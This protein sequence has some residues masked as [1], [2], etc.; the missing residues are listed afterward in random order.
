MKLIVGLGNP[1]K[2]YENTRHNVGFMAVDNYVLNEEVSKT[3]KFNGEM[4]TLNINNEKIM[5]LKPLKYM[6]LSG[7]VIKEYINYY[8]IDIEDILIIVDD[9]N[10]PLGTI[11]L[12]YKGSSGG[13]NGLED[14]ANNLQ[15]EEYK[16]LKIG[17]SKSDIISNR[18]YVL[19]KF[20]E[21]EKKELDDVI[22]ISKNVINDFL[23]LDFN[24]LMNKYNKER[25]N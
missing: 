6:N 12:K 19:G 18:D 2:E 15:T 5:L 8:K 24:N 3:I 17:I 13:H 21:K 9:L 1:G 20:S 4:Y 7:E 14:I 23:K 11:K 25:E 16:R 22:K 10:L